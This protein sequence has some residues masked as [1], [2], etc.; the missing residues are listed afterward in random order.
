MTQG[1][2]FR[3]SI[4]NSFEAKL[5]ILDKFLLL[6]DR[7]IFQFSVRGDICHEISNSSTGLALWGM[8]T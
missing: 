3:D 6:S 4:D 2:R 5:R 1:I 7:K 8:M